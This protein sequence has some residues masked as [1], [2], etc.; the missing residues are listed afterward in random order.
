[1]QTRR[2][3]VFVLGAG[4]LGQS[5][6]GAARENWLVNSA[7]VKALTQSEQ[8]AILFMLRGEVNSHVRQKLLARAR[9]NQTAFL[10]MLKLQATASLMLSDLATKN[11]GMRRFFIEYADRL[12]YLVNTGDLRNYVS[13]GD[14]ANARMRLFFES[15]GEAQIA[16]VSTQYQRRLS[17]TGTALIAFASLRVAT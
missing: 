12:R 15:L 8:M 16:A 6:A 13:D 7:W 17:D 2:T 9:N 3:F 4:L 14:W 5:D 10:F 1:M 11:E